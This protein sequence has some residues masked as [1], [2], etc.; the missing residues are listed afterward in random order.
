MNGVTGQT[1]ERFKGGLKINYH[2]K[3]RRE[4]IKKKINELARKE[5]GRGL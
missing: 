5:K 3:L 2:P 1:L 4:A